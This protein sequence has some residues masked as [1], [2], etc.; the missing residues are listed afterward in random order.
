MG[1]AA[2]RVNQLCQE[3]G[4][5]PQNLEISAAPN[6][7]YEKKDKTSQ[8][9]GVY[10]HRQKGKWYSQLWIKKGTLKSGGYSEDE[11]DAGKRVDQLCEEFEIPPQNP[12][13]SAIPNQK[14]K[15]EITSQYKG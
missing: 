1:D 10:W 13:I 8:Y 11:L 7:K 5:P 6:Q 9:K 4:I 3:S 2:K 14:K 12:E 15:R